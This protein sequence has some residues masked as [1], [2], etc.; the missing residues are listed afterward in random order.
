MNPRV[1]VRP[2][3]A[4][5]RAAILELGP[6]LAEGVAAWRDQAQA[7][8]V[9]ARWLDDSLSAALAGDGTVLVAVERDAVVGVLGVRP[10]RHFTGEL[11]A[12]IGELVV[13][14]RAARR[15]IGRSL[16]AAAAAWAREQG[17]VNLTLHTG[18]ANAAARA[19]YAALGFDE[20]EVRLTRPVTR[21][22]VTPNESG[23]G[24]LR[25]D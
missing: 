15:G 23:E 11:D 13:D 8:A 20:E 21:A 16:V 10:R 19:F 17:L 3:T 22:P 24:T 12:Y 9:G 1:V 2:A 5:D 14:R 6:R 7:L 25:S 4:A 18:A